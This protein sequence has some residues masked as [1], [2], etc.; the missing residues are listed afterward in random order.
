MRLTGI[1][2]PWERGTAGEV[3]SVGGATSG[4]PLKSTF[5][6]HLTNPAD[7]RGSFYDTYY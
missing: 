5:E 7:P 6:E 2:Q 1:P 4:T 3:I